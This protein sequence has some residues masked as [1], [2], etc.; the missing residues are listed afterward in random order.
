M[1]SIINF[2]K[3]NLITYNIIFQLN[4]DSLEYL[5]DEF[6][7]Y[8]NENNQI[9]WTSKDGDNLKMGDHAIQRQ[10]RP[11][12]K[13]G[14]GERIERNEIIDMF[15]YAWPNI[16]DMLYDGKLK[17]FYDKKHKRPVNAWTIECQCYLKEEND[18]NII[19]TNARPIE[20]TLWA[21]WMIEKN[22][23]QVNIIIKTI[24]RG[25]MLK[26][27]YNQERIRIRRNGVIEERY[28]R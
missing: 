23:N 6:I 9:V 1:K 18:K 16:I 8:I 3:E 22:G 24:F 5:S 4:E 10:D 26:H 20:K 27:S 19:P 11:I 17:S 15:K 21:V 7:Q 13:G 14:D 28:K 25:E 12:E 2:I